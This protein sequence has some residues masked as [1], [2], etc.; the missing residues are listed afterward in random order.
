M[1]VEWMR[2]AT[3]SASLLSKSDEVFAPDS[4]HAVSLHRGPHRLCGPTHIHCNNPLLV[5]RCGTRVLP[6]I[7]GARVVTRCGSRS[8]PCYTVWIGVP[9]IVIHTVDRDPH[10]VTRSVT[11]DRSSVTRSA[12]DPRQNPRSTPCNKQWI[13]AVHGHG[14]RGWSRARHLYASG[15]RPGRLATWRRMWGSGLKE[16]GSKT[17]TPEIPR[18]SL[19]W[20]SLC[21]VYG[22]PGTGGG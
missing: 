4:F 6:W 1:V 10:R 16:G 14:R 13:V 17:E 2:A 21:A 20:A 19:F 12:L 18:K 8:T 7:E 15:L 3:V 9:W 22:S 5:T 11:R